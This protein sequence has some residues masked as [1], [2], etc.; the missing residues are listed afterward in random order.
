[1]NDGFHQTAF[2]TNGST[3]VPYGSLAASQGAIYTDLASFII[4]TDNASGIIQFAPGGNTEKA[5]ISAAGNLGMGSTNPGSKITVKGGDVYV[6]T[7]GAGVILTDSAGVCWRIVPTATT[8][9]LTS[10]SVTCPAN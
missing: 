3:Y 9:T 8:G 6:T 4:L 10:T 7:V 2:G 1:V 5:R